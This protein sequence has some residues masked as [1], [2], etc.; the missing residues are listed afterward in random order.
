MEAFSEYPHIANSYADKF[1]TKCRE[2]VLPGIQWVMTEKIHG[3]NFSFHTDGTR[4]RVAR[5]SA[6]LGDTDEFHNSHLIKA[7]YEDAV[8]ALHAA[9]GVPGAIAV[10][11]ELYG[12]GYPH[13]TVK[14][15]PGVKPIQKGL[16]Y[17][18]DIHF[19][20]FD[21]VL[22]TSG[23]YLPWDQAQALSAQCG[24]PFTPLLQQGSLD[25][26]L[27]FDVE[28][29]ETR[30]PPALG[31]PPLPHMTC[32]AE[33]VVIRPMA[34]LRFADN[35][36][37]IIKVKSAKFREVTK[38]VGKE[39]REQVPVLTIANPAAYVNEARLRAVLSK[40]LE[41]KFA[42]RG[43]VFELVAP[44]LADVMEELFREAPS[45][46]ALPAA[47]LRAL[48]KELADAT[49]ALLATHADALI[50]DTF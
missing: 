30:I 38:D 3:C 43:H 47:E 22:L 34:D 24:I 10:Y 44:L 45:V 42:H 15:L 25:E 20:A 37:V 5:R 17:A 18:P 31:L 27:A 19:M 9:I 39:A 49:K 29:F 32:I 8:K 13:A 48:K 11:G 2:V 28:T 33:G 41:Q 6:F 1:L 14:A 35:T 21:I 36:R 12:G 40:R 26:L 46:A 16:F 50:A 4:V 23:A 7:K